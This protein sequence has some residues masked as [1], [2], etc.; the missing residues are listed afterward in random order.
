MLQKKY[1]HYD[2]VLKVLL[3]FFNYKNII[4]TV[5]QFK[6]NK[7]TLYYWCEWWLYNQ[8]FF[9]K[10]KS[11]KKRLDLKKNI[12]WKKLKIQTPFINIIYIKLFTKLKKSLHKN[13]C[14][15]YLKKNYSYRLFIK[16]FLKKDYNVITKKNLINYFLKY[17]FVSTY[18]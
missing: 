7:K 12:F 8:I 10:I 9:K 11:M 2:F 5:F 3:H 17:E 4:K 18:Y 16:N 15:Y 6:I 13:V 1:Y 14:Y